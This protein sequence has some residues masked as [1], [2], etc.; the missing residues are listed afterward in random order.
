MKSDPYRGS[1]RTC[2]RRGFCR[3]CGRGRVRVLPWLHRQGTNTQALPM[4]LNQS[5]TDTLHSV[6]YFFSSVFEKYH[7]NLYH[8]GPYDRSRH[9]LLE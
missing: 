3:R 2:F 6:F 8:F 5:S 9:L 1:M 7:M 4:K